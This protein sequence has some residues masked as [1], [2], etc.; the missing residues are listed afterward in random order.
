MES[1]S[2]LL[3]WMRFQEHGDRCGA[4]ESVRLVKLGDFS[5]GGLVVFRRGRV[6]SVFWAWRGDAD[7][8]QARQE[9]EEVFDGDEF[10]VVEVCGAW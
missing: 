5:R 9:V 7:L 4:M 2:V 3:G 6:W 8:G 1:F 10:V